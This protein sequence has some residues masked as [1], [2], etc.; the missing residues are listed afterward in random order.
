LFIGPLVH[1][2]THTNT[3]PLCIYYVPQSGLST[4]IYTTYVVITTNV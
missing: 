2:H 4:L 3:V 1:T